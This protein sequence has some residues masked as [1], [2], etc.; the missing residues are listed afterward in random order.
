MALR[1]ERSDCLE[2]AGARRFELCGPPLCE[3]GGRGEG[4]DR[5]LGRTDEV[6]S[7]GAAEADRV[8]ARAP[9]G[10]V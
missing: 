8:L 7:S 2:E 4:V 3:L 9:V 1:A 5:P 6:A 10:S